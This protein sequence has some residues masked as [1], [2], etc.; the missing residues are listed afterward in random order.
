MTIAEQ[1]EQAGI[2]KGIEQG[3]QQSIEQGIQPGRCESRLAVKR[4]LLEMGLPGET[5]RQA[6]GRSGRRSAIDR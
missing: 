3:I 5:V 1:L 4:R 2:K 6:A